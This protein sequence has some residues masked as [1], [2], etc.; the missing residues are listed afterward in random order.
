MFA[1]RPHRERV[2]EK[3][4]QQYTVFA[5]S[6]SAID[7]IASVRL[8]PGQRFAIEAVE[9]CDRLVSWGNSVMI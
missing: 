8:G 6:A 7:R 2:M 5:D 9:A 4:D 1:N 3:R